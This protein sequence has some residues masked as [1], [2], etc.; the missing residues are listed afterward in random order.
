MFCPRD[1]DASGAKHTGDLDWAN[2][3]NI[4]SEF[5]PVT[6]D[7]NPAESTYHKGKLPW[8]QLE[9]VPDLASDTHDN[10]AHDP[11]FAEVG[12]DNSAHSETY[13]VSATERIRYGAGQSGDITS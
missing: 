10:G 5:A 4:P 7:I 8:N 3:K 11:D 6:H 13:L 9:D 2:L 1:P 12:H